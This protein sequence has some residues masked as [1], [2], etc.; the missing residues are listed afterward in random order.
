MIKRAALVLPEKGYESAYEYAN[1]KF[2]MLKKQ[3]DISL[4]ILSNIDEAHSKHYQYAK[5][6]LLTGRP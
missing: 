5:R 2:A 1:I 4:G 6:R 3:I